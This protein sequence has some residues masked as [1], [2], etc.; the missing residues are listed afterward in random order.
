MAIN[1]GNSTSLANVLSASWRITSN[2][3]GNQN[4][5]TNNWER[6]DNTGTGNSYAN[7]LTESSGVF[8][9]T[10]TGWYTVSWS[11]YCYG[12]SIDA[13]WCEM[14]MDI[15]PNSGSNWETLGHT[16]GFILSDSTMYQIPTRTLNF[17]I[18]NSNYRIRFGIVNNNGSVIT[19]GSSTKQH[20]GFII[21][22]VAEV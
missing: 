22:K 21:H 20:T 7:V 6:A 14:N 16:Q 4:P 2:F 5:V 12:Q 19:A 17:K 11:H 18:P 15:S 1:F 10:Y 8:S 3:T 9:F 13:Y